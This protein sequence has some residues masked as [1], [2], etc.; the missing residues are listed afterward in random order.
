MSYLSQNSA[1][2]EQFCILRTLGVAVNSSSIIFFAL[3]LLGEQLCALL[4]C[5]RSHPCRGPGRSGFPLDRCAPSLSCCLGLLGCKILLSPCY[6]QS[7]P[8]HC[9][10]FCA[11]ILCGW[12]RGSGSCQQI[13][14]SSCWTSYSHSSWAPLASRWNTPAVVCH[15]S[16]CWLLGCLSSSLLKRP[17]SNGIMKLCLESCLAVRKSSFLPNPGKVGWRLEF[18]SNFLITV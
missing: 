9:S 5:P 17:P 13:L 8:Q 18:L 15:G 10:Y 3:M 14:S 11:E 7:L 12:E 4:K 2:Q 6:A 16:R 1:E